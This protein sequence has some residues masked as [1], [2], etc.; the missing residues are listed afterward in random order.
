MSRLKISLLRPAKGDR[1]LARARVVRAGKTLIV[2]AGDAFAVTD[3][4]EAAVA[5][6]LA[7][8]MAVEQRDDLRH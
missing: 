2:C 5:T 3:G 8:V 4:A 7:T 6:M 1:L